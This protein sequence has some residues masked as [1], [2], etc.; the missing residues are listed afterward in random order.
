MR[1][2]IF[3]RLRGIASEQFDINENGLQFVSAM[4]GFLWINEEQRGFDPTIVT[5]GDK[6]YIEIKREN[7]KE[8][9]VINRLIERRVHREGDPGTPLVVKD[10]WQYPEREEEGELLREATKKEVMNVTR[11]FHYE[12]ISVGSRDDDIRA[13]VRKGL[14]ITKATNYKPEKPMPPPS[15]TGRRAS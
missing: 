7:G 6:R 10:S 5:V 1:L 14:D 11:Y 3:D 13:N 15:T 4:L 8:C 9:L 2:W 12:M